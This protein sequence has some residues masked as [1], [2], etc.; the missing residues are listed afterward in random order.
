MTK[1]DYMNALKLALQDLPGD[2]QEELL[3]T[4]EGKFIDGMVADKSEQEV[5]A[6][7]PAPALVAIQQKAAI[8]LRQFKN[9][10]SVGN[11]A[12]L[13]VALFGLMIFNLLMLIPALFCFAMLSSAFITA[14][15]LYFAGIFLTAG[16]ITGVDELHIHDTPY[17]LV[18]DHSP[19][20]ANSQINKQ[21]GVNISSSGIQVNG[22]PVAEGDRQTKRV[23]VI[24]PVDI[25]IN[26]GKQLDL[27]DAF[28]GIGM[29]IGSVLLL[30]LSMFLTAFSFR[31]FRQY[32]RWNFSQL[33]LTPAA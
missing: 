17:Q 32:L 6:R 16:G 25:H 9:K 5:I 13:I 29:V 28:K 14:L 3:W 11:L 21:A 15:S 31:G 2:V 33:R 23:Q 30:M 27:Y 22:G 4:Y 12:R 7:L 18:V 20:T 8:H 26:L 10:V 1:T 19:A 24:E